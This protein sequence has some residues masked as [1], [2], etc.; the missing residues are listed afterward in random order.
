MK[1]LTVS[2]REIL[3]E[4]SKIGDFLCSYAKM[5]SH[6]TY[7]DCIDYGTKG[8]SKSDYDVYGG[9]AG[10]SLFLLELF[11][12]TGKIQYKNAAENSI[13]HVL[14]AT[15]LQTLPPTFLTGRLGIAFILLRFGLLTEN[16]SYF[17]KALEIS[18]DSQDVLEFQ[19]LEYLNGISGSLLAMLHVHSVTNNSRLLDT[20]N[21][22]IYI[23]IERNNSS[24]HGVFWDRTH[25]NNQGLCGFSHGSSG[26]GFVF[27][28]A[29]HYLRMPE[30]Y[31]IAKLAF[32]YENQFV[33]VE[34]LNW[35]DF[36]NEIIAKDHPAIY[37]SSYKKGDKV[38]F[39]KAARMNAWC[40]GAA[41]I[42]LARMGCFR[43]LDQEYKYLQDILIAL[44]RNYQSEIIKTP[45]ESWNLCHGSA[46]NAEVFL[47]AFTNFNIPRYRQYARHVAARIV[48]KVNED[49]HYKFLSQFGSID[50]S[51]FLGISGIGYFLLR[52]LDPEG[53][54]SILLPVIK[55]QLSKQYEK[56]PYRRNTRKGFVAALLEPR[57]SRTIG[58]LNVAFKSQWKTFYAQISSFD[59][60]KVDFIDFILGLICAGK[61][62]HCE[63]LKDVFNL[64][65]TITNI[66]EFV[67]SYTLLH[68]KEKMVAEDSKRL[69][70]MND[71][72]LGRQ[73]LMINSDIH[74]LKTKWNWFGDSH[75]AHKKT[76]PTETTN[77]LL[78]S[79]LTGIKEI[80]IS[81]LTAVVLERFRSTATVGQ[82][83]NSIL[84][85]IN[86]NQDKSSQEILFQQIR[87]LISVGFIL[88]PTSNPLNNS[89][90]ITDR[91]HSE[92]LLR[93]KY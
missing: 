70:N 55:G 23:L 25:S 49:R 60:L 41:G 13:K 58:L 52:T 90:Y 62:N 7:W 43:Y 14:E 30:C 75:R 46:G 33:D 36:R 82:V 63:R 57:F 42:G 65:L 53:T 76:K 17:R 32:Q 78:F 4:A 37:D 48:H 74:L 85:E 44:S 9:I 68:H 26:I 6:G 81:K 16:K 89:N 8:T 92:V 5:D 51:L 1:T 40:H 35:P 31:E 61:S 21:Q 15:N 38:F 86:K 18:L 79:R 19:A 59:S 24:R 72:V 66:D 88:D 27:G 45:S 11:H 71:K 50:N 47:E 34:G 3:K 64:E 73:I 56:P 28:Q 84:K 54:P 10:I 80:A 20:I 93:I 67:S 2:D 87:H 69:L 39:T 91:I 83:V 77:V 29:G 22:L 12:K